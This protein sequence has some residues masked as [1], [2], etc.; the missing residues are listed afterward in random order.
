MWLRNPSVNT[1]FRSISKSLGILAVQP[2]ISCDNLVFFFSGDNISS[3]TWGVETL[4][5][6]PED[7]TPRSIRVEEVCFFGFGLGTSTYLSNNRLFKVDC[8]LKQHNHDLI[9]SFGL[10]SGRISAKGAAVPRRVHSLQNQ[11]KN[12]YNTT[13]KDRCKGAT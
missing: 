2:H 12:C 11:L 9:L 5:G 8:Y 3:P 1:F 13:K 4:Q 7:R 6:R 10:F